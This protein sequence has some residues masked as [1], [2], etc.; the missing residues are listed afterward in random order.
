MNRFNKLQ[1]LINNGTSST[2]GFSKRVD[3]LINSKYT[4][5]E[6]ILSAESMFNSID[7]EMYAMN[8]AIEDLSFEYSLMKR[9]ENCS[10]ESIE[11]LTMFEDISYQMGFKGMEDIKEKMKDMSGK[12]VEKLK[13]VF[14]KMR[15][16]FEGLFAGIKKKL[17]GIGGNLVSKIPLVQKLIKLK[18]YAKMTIPVLG[19]A[20]ATFIIVKKDQ[21]LSLFPKLGEVF[22]N[23]STKIKATLEGIKQKKLPDPEKLKN[24]VLEYLKKAL[25][26]LGDKA[27]QAKDLLAGGA[28]DL[29]NMV[30]YGMANPKVVEKPVD[31]ILNEV[32]PEML[33]Q[34]S[35]FWQGLNN[36][37]DKSKSIL[38]VIDIAKGLMNTVVDFGKDKMKALNDLKL[39]QQ[40]MSAIGN[41]LSTASKIGYN[42]KSTLEKAINALLKK[43]ENEGG[44]ENEGGNENKEATEN[45]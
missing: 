27:S 36:M 9:F 33:D 32:P 26:F 10:K 11:S 28:K 41:I 42:I 8:R 38:G 1:K 35:S 24:D 19:A 20:G 34:K 31:A 16:A 15:G 40:I 29:M 13:A 25:S 23:V 5:N 3:E 2:E 4:A 39:V 18:K 14:G 43:K 30:F 17:A 12:M 45:A 44:S 22:N 21:L 7:N 6:L 37:L